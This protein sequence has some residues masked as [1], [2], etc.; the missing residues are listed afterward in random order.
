MGISIHYLCDPRKTLAPRAWV[1]SSLEGG[2]R[3]W[4]ITSRMLRELQLTWPGAE[5]PSLPRVSSMEEPGNWDSGTQPTGHSLGSD[6]CSH[7]AKRYDNVAKESMRAEDSIQANPKERLRQ[8]DLENEMWFPLFWFKVKNEK[9]YQAGLS[10]QRLLQD[11]MS[12]QKCYFNWCKCEGV[13]TPGIE[14]LLKYTCVWGGGNRALDPENAKLLGNCSKPD[15]E[16]IR[17]HLPFR[18]SLV[19]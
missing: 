6:S 3:K 17:C 1:S 11:H 18:A 10:L 16:G 9:G 4:K 13:G 14:F 5:S 8:V 7:Q 2:A 19:L 12:L 15:T